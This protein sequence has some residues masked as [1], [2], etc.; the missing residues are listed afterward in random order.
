MKIFGGDQVEFLSFVQRWVFLQIVK[1]NELAVAV[2]KPEYFLSQFERLA[3]Q[4][5]KALCV[6]AFGQGDLFGFLFEDE[7]QGV[8]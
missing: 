1:T 3:D 2:C 5:V 4:G 7:V 6:E 8:H